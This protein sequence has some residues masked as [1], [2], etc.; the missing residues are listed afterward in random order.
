[1]GDFKWNGFP[2]YF[3]YFCAL[4]NCAFVAYTLSS[5]FSGHVCIAF[6]SFPR[7]PYFVCKTLFF[8][9]SLVDLHNFLKVIFFFLSDIF[10][11]LSLL[12]ALMVL[13]AAYFLFFGAVFLSSAKSFVTLPTFIISYCLCWALYPQTF[14][15][16]FF[17]LTFIFKV[18]LLKVA[19]ASVSRLMMKWYTERK[20]LSVY[21]EEE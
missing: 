18:T 21:S 1:M 9:F 6:L 2:L 10:I 14:A 13:W 7:W 15:F 12:S 16:C 17:H 5:P 8:Y 4:S 19:Q 11:I 20:D 3:W